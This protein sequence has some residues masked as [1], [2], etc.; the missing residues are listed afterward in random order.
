VLVS[1][2]KRLYIATGEGILSILT[3]Q[4]AGKRHMTAEE[5]LRGYQVKPSDVFGPSQ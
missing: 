4:P 1:D 2:G 5:F 3:L